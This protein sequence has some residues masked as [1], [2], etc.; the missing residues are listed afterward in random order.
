MNMF[1]WKEFQFLTNN[2]IFMFGWK[3]INTTYIYVNL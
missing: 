2:F 3:R 1:P